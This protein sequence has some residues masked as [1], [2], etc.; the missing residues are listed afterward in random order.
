MKAKQKMEK[1]CYLY[2][3][4]IHCFFL[5]FFLI[6]CFILLCCSSLKR[7]LLL[8][9]RQRGGKKDL[10]KRGRGMMMLGIMYFSLL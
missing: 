6:C 7:D 9:W 3:I 8:M 10:N 5:V 2:V 4:L 1:V